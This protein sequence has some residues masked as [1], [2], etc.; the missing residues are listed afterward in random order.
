M[1]SKAGT[2]SP[3]L[4]WVFGILA[5]GVAFGATWGLAK[6]GIYSRPVQYAVFALVFLGFGF[7]STYLTKASLGMS[8]AASAVGA[9]VVAGLTYWQLTSGIGAVSAAGAKI[10]SAAT[11]AADL[12]AA[13]KS[14]GSF[15]STFA[16]I[17]VAIVFG[18]GLAAG[19][20]GNIAG[21]KFA[22]PKQA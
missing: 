19:I 15:L 13:V 22:A 16:I 21:K 14:A 12:G 20:S 5:G 10:A 3:G 2:L 9:L 11:G 6:A 7:A 17:P 1:S 8:I 18:I 4:A